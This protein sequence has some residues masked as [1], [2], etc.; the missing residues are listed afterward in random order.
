MMFLHTRKGKLDLEY[1]R[2]LLID[3]DML[4][5]WQAFG[6]VLVDKL[7]LPEDEFPFFDRAQEDKVEKIIRRVLNEGNFGRERS[8][9]K[10]RGT[11]YLLNKTRSFFGHIGK[12]ADLVTIFPKQVWHQYKSTIVGG[13]KVVFVDLKIKM[14]GNRK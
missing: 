11:N 12:S 10:N 3:M 7:D 5:P 14:S 2:K 6:C 8:V 1:L 9:F 4:M 13:F